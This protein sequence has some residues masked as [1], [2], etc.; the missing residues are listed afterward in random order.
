MKQIS[1]SLKD[2]LHKK[3]KAAAAADSRSL[4]NWLR[5]LIE[6]AVKESG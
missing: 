6:A 2:S 4:A 3:A 5:R 1:I